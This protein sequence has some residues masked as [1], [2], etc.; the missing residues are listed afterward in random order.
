[1]MKLLCIV[2]LELCTIVEFGFRLHKK[3]KKVEH[4][5]TNKHYKNKKQEQKKKK[6]KKSV[7][8]SNQVPVVGT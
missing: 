2:L 1:M 4:T 7:H 8:S 3:E 5:K 6:K